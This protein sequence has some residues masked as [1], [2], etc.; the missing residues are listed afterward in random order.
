MHLFFWER[1]SQD[2]KY[3]WVSYVQE[4]VPGVTVWLV[5]E[6]SID[7]GQCEVEVEIHDCEEGKEEDYMLV[8]CFPA[9]GIGALTG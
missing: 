1:Y 2:E 5:D 4:D 9:H 7:I 3:G 6:A 8:I